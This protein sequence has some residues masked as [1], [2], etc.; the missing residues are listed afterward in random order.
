MRKSIQTSIQI[1]A[2]PARVWEVLSD[3][4]KYPE[5]NPFVSALYGDVAVGKRIKVKL[6]GM[7]F[8]PKVLIFKPLEEFR[9]RG[10]LFFPGL[11]DGEHSFKIEQTSSNSVVFRHEEYFSGI[12]VPL[13][14]NMLDG[15]TK[16]GFEA[17]NQALKLRAES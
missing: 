4:E 16:A 12:L 3:F 2:S 6:P 10:N 5:W 11:F 17:M 13:F 8:T 1:N 7:N 15:K 9:W 14:K